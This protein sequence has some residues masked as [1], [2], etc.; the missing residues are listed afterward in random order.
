[1]MAYSARRVE[2]SCSRV[3]RPPSVLKAQGSQENELWVL[4]NTVNLPATYSENRHP[5]AKK[6]TLSG[7][8]ISL[9]EA[10]F[11]IFYCVLK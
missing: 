11:M 1:M 10:T 3:S 9:M 4:G 6:G 2:A 5:T 8:D 7:E